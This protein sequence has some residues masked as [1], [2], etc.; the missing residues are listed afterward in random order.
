[1][2]TGA[3]IGNTM[4]V[5]GLGGALFDKAV[6]TLPSTIYYVGMLIAGLCIIVPW[7]VKSLNKMEKKQGDQRSY[8]SIDF[9]DH[10]H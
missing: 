1:M 2:N 4:A 10:W 9:G 3:T 7:V 5:I 8:Q 6:P